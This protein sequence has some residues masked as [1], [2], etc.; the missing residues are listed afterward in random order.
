MFMKITMGLLHHKSIMGRAIV[1]LLLYRMA[2]IMEHNTLY[3]KL[4]KFSTR[5][6][7]LCNFY[8]NIVFLIAQFI[9]LGR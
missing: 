6:F 1:S 9:L 3:L 2:K 4:L 7:Q 8:F 5:L